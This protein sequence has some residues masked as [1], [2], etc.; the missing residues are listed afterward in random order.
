MTTEEILSKIEAELT[1]DPQKDMELLSKAFKKYYRRTDDVKLNEELIDKITD[2]FLLCYQN[3]DFDVS[4]FMSDFGNEYYNL[5]LYVVR[6]LARK[7]E[8]EKAY[9]ICV[10]I[11]N[12]ILDR[13]EGVR[14]SFKE[15]GPITFRYYFTGMEKTIADFY[16][17]CEHIFALPYD[18]IS[19]L[20]LKVQIVYDLKGF[21]EAMYV[22]RQTNDYNPVHVAS[23]FLACNMAWESGNEMTFISLLDRIQ[24]YIYDDEDFRNYLHQISRYYEKHD[25]KELA[26]K[27][28]SCFC[29]EAFYYEGLLNLDPLVKAEVEKT[30]KLDINPTL[31]TLAVSKYLVAFKKKRQQEI[32]YYTFISSNLANP[33]VINKEME[34][35]LL[36]NF[37]KM[38]RRRR[39]KP[40]NLNS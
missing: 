11:E 40:K 14:K 2:H 17:P 36:D 27:L 39:E 25:Q 24:P 19:L 4:F 28:E 23:A 10:A 13:M 20:L 37:D 15:P 16:F 7:K 22:F 6:N 8:M 9:N 34:M 3:Q 38:T 32:D 18:I 29:E 30:F 12:Y 35:Q 1:N 33:D 21:N 31:I 26:D 5:G